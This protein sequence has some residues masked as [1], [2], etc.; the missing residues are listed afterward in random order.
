[1]GLMEYGIKVHIEAKNDEIRALNGTIEAVSDT[2][3]TIK[4]EDGHIYFVP[5]A[6]IGY[7]RDD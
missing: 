1:M 3:V 2:G 5:Y 6:A 7:I 4:E